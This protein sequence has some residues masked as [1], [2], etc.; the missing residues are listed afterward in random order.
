MRSSRRLSFVLVILL[1]STGRAE[2]PQAASVE[3]SSGS[4]LV[5]PAVVATWIVRKEP[6][7][8]SQLEL[9]VLWRGTPGWFMRAGSEESSNSDSIQSTEDDRGGGTVVERLSYGGLR[10][11]L[12][13]VRGKRTARV[14]NHDVGLESANVILVDEVDAVDGPQIAGSLH[15]DP[16]FASEPA[17]VEAIVRRSPEIYEFLRC[18][19]S[20]PDANTQEVIETLCA[21]MK[22][23]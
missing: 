18:D 20:V 7:G 14:Q 1:A 16:S 11:E 19:A 12:E 17:E 21:R 9:L 13:F 10:L 15:V 4:R 3:S 8:T 22:P 2:S 6:H 5:S 23:K